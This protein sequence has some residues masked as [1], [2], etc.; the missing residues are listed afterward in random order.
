[1]CGICGFNWDDKDLLKSMLNSMK[2]R[3]PDHSDKYIDNNFSLGYNRLSIIDLKKGN[4]PIYN[5]DHSLVLFFNGEIYNYKELRKKLEKKHDFITNTDSEVVIHAYEEYGVNFLHK[6]DGMFGFVIYD[7]KK[8]ELF[9]ARD[10]LGIKPLYYYSDKKRFIFASELK[11]I[12]CFEETNKKLSFSAFN[13]YLT[14]RYC[15]GQ[16]TIFSK[17]KKIKPGHYLRFVKGKINIKKYWGLDFKVN[18]ESFETSVKK[19]GE[20]LETSIK[21]RLISDVPV[22]ALLSGGIDSSAIVALMAKNTEHP[23]KTYTLGFEEGNKNE[24]KYARI[25]A[26]KFGTEHKEFMINSSYI[27]TLPKVIWHLDEPIADPTAIPNYVLAK[28]ASKDVKVLLNGEGADE[29]FMG[30][31]QYKKMTLLRYYN[32]L[33][34]LIRKT[35]LKAVEFLPKEPF[36]YKLKDFINLEKNIP[37][38]YLELISVFGTK[39]KTMVVKKPLI[40]KMSINQ[41]EKNIK[42]YFNNKLDYYTKQSYHDISNFLPDNMLVKYDKTT[43][44]HSVEGRVPFC[45]H[46][47]GEFAA[48]LPINYKLNSR[49]DKYI[50]RKSM[51]NILPR[52]IIKRPKQRFFVPTDIWFKKEFGDYSQ[53]ILENNKEIT[54]RFFNIKYIKKLLDKDK[55]ISNTILKANPMTKLYYSR[56]LWTVT[57]FVLWHDLYVNE[58][59]KYLKK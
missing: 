24:F 46:K 18:N 7:T 47:I 55:M 21:N 57:N 42:S 26:D 12:L 16:Q 22:G 33:P 17:I 19:F 37:K 27:N 25:V 3:G 5:E 10:R 56:Q 36:F 52:S 39:E 48:S 9:M 29:F 23:V 2:H 20:L 40:K 28:K 35:V 13:D 6:L 51:K 58:S 50:L 54:N 11:A 34:K 1:M 8:K 15:R 44:A 45:D 32:N 41:S 53:S 38:S 43:M 49:M 4:Q 59:D 14:Y 30:Y 31:E